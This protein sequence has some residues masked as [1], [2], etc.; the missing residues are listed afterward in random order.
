MWKTEATFRPFKSM[1]RRLSWLVTWRVSIDFR[2]FPGFDV[3]SPSIGKMKFCR[4]SNGRDSRGEQEQ[5]KFERRVQRSAFPFSRD[6]NLRHSF[7]PCI[8]GVKLK[9]ISNEGKWSGWIWKG[10]G[11]FCAFS[12]NAYLRHFLRNA[13]ALKRSHWPLKRWEDLRKTRIGQQLDFGELWPWDQVVRNSIFT[14]R[15]E[16][17]NALPLSL[18]SSLLSPHSTS[19]ELEISWR[20]QGTIRANEGCRSFCRANAPGILEVTLPQ[21]LQQGPDCIVS[22]FRGESRPIH[23]YSDFWFHSGR[24][25]RPDVIDDAWPRYDLH[26]RR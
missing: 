18:F 5:I 15:K 26:R 14:R 24:W 2:F 23:L 1:R 11:A 21:F 4:H 20:V 9:Q 16:W 12:N 3:S 7:D 6:F 13:T 25:L 22:S 17:M 10:F 19:S 8:R